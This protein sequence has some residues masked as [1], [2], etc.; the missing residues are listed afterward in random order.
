MPNLHI[1]SL[2]LVTGTLLGLF[3]L[4]V[5]IWFLVRLK[6]QKIW[7]PTLRII[8]EE[9]KQVPKLTIVPPPLLSFL[10]FVIAAAVLIFVSL[11]PTRLIEADKTPT[12]E[13]YHI[14][15]D[16]SPSV[17][18]GQTIAAYSQRIDQ[19]VR[20]IDKE[21]SI[22][23]S[24]SHGT[25]VAFSEE[26]DL[27]GELTKLGFHRSGVKMG[28]WMAKHLQSRDKIDKLIIVSDA[29]LHSWKDFNW[30]YLKENTDFFYY[31]AHADEDMQGL[32]FFINRA[33]FTSTPFSP[34]IDWEVEI[35]ANQPVESDIK[36]SLRVVYGPKI[37]KEIPWYMQAGNRQTQVKIDWPES[38]VDAR[39]RADEPHLKWELVVEDELTMDNTYYTIAN[40]MKQE[41]LVVSHPIGENFLDNPNHHITT[42]LET[43]G[44]KVRTFDKAPDESFDY[45]HYPVWI[46]FGGLDSEGTSFCPN[47]TGDQG[48][49]RGGVTKIWLAPHDE[50]ANYSHLCACLTKLS[51]INSDFCSDVKGRDDWIA[52]LSSFDAK[53]VGGNV[54]KVLESLAWKYVP[55]DK[56]LEI[57]AFTIPL[58]PFAG[59]SI[60]YLKFPLFIKNILEWQNVIKSDDLEKKDLVPR[61]DDITSVTETAEPTNVPM[62]ESI[63]A[64]LEAKALPPLWRES[65]SEAADSLPAGQFKSDP[66]FWIQICLAVLA[67]AGTIE[68][69]GKIILLVTKARKKRILSGAALA[70]L[71]FGFPTDG[72]ASIYLNLV[73]YPKAEYTSA[74]IAKEVAG[75]TSITISDKIHFF[76][77]VQEGALQHPWIWAYNPGAVTHE[78][79]IK[80][81]LVSWLYRGGLLIIENARSLEELQSLTSGVPQLNGQW[82]VVPPD[83]ELMRSFHLLDTLPVCENQFWWGFHYDGRLV[84]LAAPFSLAQ[85]ILTGQKPG[86]CFGNQFQESAT[87]T[88]INILM[89][90]LTTDYKKDQIHLPEIL[91]RLR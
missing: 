16:M 78:G 11:K 66:M 77:S 59:T 7:L 37:L 62:G 84:L 68:A 26:M 13:N 27:Q 9:K 91:K 72:S 22:V 49:N 79:K 88:F 23:I 31:P 73:G 33:E 86:T 87:R 12:G 45:E 39:L 58:R 21:N 75:R 42:S 24:T 52:A 34:T 14:L 46:L 19:M 28:K 50:S 3:G 48:L 65:G 54:G 64:T 20:S 56:G 74:F 17:A 53:Q 83:H 90:A 5:L 4:S 81:E 35:F 71:A 80:P 40:G 44:F 60:S 61:I 32:N 41:L 63:L 67:L 2:T 29:D 25:N 89:V 30:T 55:K 43:L 36:G 69:I 85:A 38:N 6:R 1:S 47:L 10:M 15:L 8:E 51:G 70:L 82:Q 76:D 18:R 57:L